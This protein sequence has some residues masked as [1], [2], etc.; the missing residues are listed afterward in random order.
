MPDLNCK[1]ALWLNH[2]LGCFIG[3][4]FGIFGS[5]INLPQC[6]SV[7][8]LLGDHFH[9]FML[10]WAHGNGHFQQGNSTTHLNPIEHLW[11]VLELGLKG[12][13][14]APTNL[15][16][17]WTT[18]ANIWQVIPVERFQELVNQPMSYEVQLQRRFLYHPLA[19]G[20]DNLPDS[21]L[22]LAEN[23]CK[24]VAHT[25]IFQ[26]GRGSG[27]E[28]SSFLYHAPFDFVDIRE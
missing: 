22:V 13:H 20:E 11:D 14:T 24:P 19:V 10:F 8:E 9:P 23:G 12:H 21:K 18:F 6:N 3:A 7:V 15:T 1:K 26:G 5:C 2:V 27:I 16:E 17:L 25:G 4:L 28:S